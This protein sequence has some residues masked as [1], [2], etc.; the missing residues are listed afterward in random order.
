[1]GI[2]RGVT[3]GGGMGVRRRGERYKRDKIWGGK[4]KKKK[5]NKR[6]LIVFVM[7]GLKLLK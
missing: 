1:M 6:Y 4:R 7:K 5:G 3:G 2:M